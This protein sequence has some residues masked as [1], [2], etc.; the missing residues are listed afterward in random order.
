MI[1][2]VGAERH[3]RAMLGML[4]GEKLA[5]QSSAW[6]G[7]IPCF[8]MNGS[9]HAYGT[10]LLS[11]ATVELASSDVEDWQL[12]RLFGEN[13]VSFKLCFERWGW[14]L[15]EKSL[16]RQSNSKILVPR[17]LSPPKVLTLDLPSAVLV[18]WSTL[19][20]G[21]HSK[22]FMSFWVQAERVPKIWVGSLNGQTLF[23]GKASKVTLIDSH[24]QIL[25]T[26]QSVSFRG[27]NHSAWL[28]HPPCRDWYFVPCRSHPS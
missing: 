16:S 19:A 15:R 8:T 22:Y 6:S 5:S 14:A 26:N 23:L 20:L 13:R 11:G 1:G 24:V 18:N 3:A 17:A 27:T 4:G 25:L 7:W 12:L 2:K 10:V 28:S 9:R 21:Q